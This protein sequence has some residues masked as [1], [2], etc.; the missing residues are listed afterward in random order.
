MYLRTYLNGYL[1]INLSNFCV[2]YWL[3]Q[4]FIGSIFEGEKT[5]TNPNLADVSATPA[6]Y[7]DPNDPNV[8]PTPQ[9]ELS[10]QADFVEALDPGWD[11]RITTLPAY[12]F[13]HVV[14]YQKKNPYDASEPMVGSQGG[15]RSNNGWLLD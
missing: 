2:F 7:K 15:G 10:Y 6:N 12:Q 1:H 8:P 13:G 5:M 14:F 11:T 4:M 3:F 9:R